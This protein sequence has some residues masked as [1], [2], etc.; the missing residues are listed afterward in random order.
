[1]KLE[2]LRGIG[3][4]RLETLAKNGITSLQTLLATLPVAY[5][6]ALNPT[7]ICHLT[8]GGHCVE[9][10]LLDTP[11]RH[12]Y[13][14]KSA[15]RIRLGDDT[16]VLSLT[17]FNQP[18]MAN[19]LKKGETLLLYGRVNSYQGAVSMVNPKKIQERSIQPLYRAMPGL[20]GRTF[21]SLV[22]QALEVMSDEEAETLPSWFLDRQNLCG[23]RAA[24]QQAHFPEN[25][26]LLAQAKRRLAFENLLL[27]QAALF[28]VGRR[29]RAGVRFSCQMSDLER[30]WAALPFSP[31]EAQKAALE[32]VYDDLHSGYLMRRLVQ[33]DV[34]SGKT[35]VAFGAAW[36]S[37]L[38]GYQ[39]A[40]MA[41]TDILAQQ[42]YM[43]AERLLSPLGV[44][45]GLLTG[46]LGAKERR[47][48]HAH[49]A[50]GAWQ[51]VI[52][53]QALIS[54]AVQYHNLGL[55]ITD[56]QHRFGVQQRQALAEKPGNDSEAHMLTLS[57]TPIPRSL[58]LVLYGDLEVSLIQEKP[59]GRL[60]VKTRIVPEDKRKQLYSYIL[61]SAR[62]GEQCFYVC[63]L[64][65]EDEEQ[66]ARSVK[67]TYAFLRKGPLKALRLGLTY[68]EQEDA[69]KAQTLASFA[70]GEL[71]VLVASSVIEVG[72]DVPGATIMVIEGAERFGLAQLHQLRGRVGRGKKESWC[73][74]LGQ[75]NDRLRVMTQSEDGFFIAQKDLDQ[76]GP[77]EFFGTR[78][79]G[80]DLPDAYGVGDIRLIEET[81]A[82]LKSLAQDEEQRGFM[83]YLIDLS[84]RQY[85]AVFSSG[86]H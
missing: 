69:Q 77:G 66:S 68:G 61:E 84:R 36:L 25:V 55:V 23:K 49:I 52:G 30:F 27:Y 59:P 47:E 79:H 80:R 5:I 31:T 60:P 51:L 42:H 57:A 56:E 71:D 41:P 62:R 29:G 53:T 82:C 8:E 1:M 10:V 18:W 76:R 20:P 86:K 33:G 38:S 32:D 26:E 3:P 34:G 63:P 50:S 44:R 45:C 81:T 48:A 74:L 37:A 67:E 73:F 83:Q 13:G 6:N 4:K 35:A 72:V 75:P 22:R 15:V 85:G 64:V 14:G 46:S 17:W 11:R 70:A 12:F 43:N 40:M 58:A 21:S 65:E 78:Q 54:G 19:Q 2:D 28:E 16:G 24:W 39:C 7:P 9:G